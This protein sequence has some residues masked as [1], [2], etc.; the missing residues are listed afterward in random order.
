M[1]DRWGIRR[2]LSVAIVVSLALVLGLIGVGTVAYMNRMLKERVYGEAQAAVG[3]GA[4]QI[5]GFFTERGRVVTT[6]LE[7]PELRSW[8]ESYRDFRRPLAGDRGYRHVT[9]LFRRIVEDDPTVLSAFFAVAS[10]GEYFKHDG[11]VER[12]GYD[13]RK[14]WW[15][16]EALDAGG[17]Y[18]SRP[19]MDAET[20]DIAV[21]VQTTVRD[22]T[23]RLVGVSGIDV[24]LTTVGEL[25]ERIRY[26]GVGTAFLTDGEGRVVYFP[27]VEVVHDPDSGLPELTRAV[28]G[29]G[30]DELERR[31]VSAPAGVARVTWKGEPQLAFWTPVR[32]ER[33][34]LEWRLGLL[35]PEEVVLRPLRR[36]RWLSA[37]AVLFTIA[38]A[39]GV[40]LLATSAIVTRPIGRLVDRFRD[41]ASGEGDLT[42]SVVVESSD[43]LGELAE[44]FNRFVAGIRSDVAAIAGLSGRLSEASGELE[45]LAHRIAS[46]TEETSSQAGSVSAAAEQVNVSVQSVAAAAEQ[47]GSSIAE[48]AKSAGEAA[49]V[50]GEA[51][52]IARETVS[53]FGELTA[54]GEQIVRVVEVIRGIAEQT[55]L[56]ALNATIEAARAGEAGRGFAVVAGEVKALARQTA[57]ATEEIE[58]SLASIRE[59]TGAAGEAIDRVVG[60]IDRIHEIQTVIASAV[61]EQSATTAEI[62]QNVAEAA[63]GVDEIARSVAGFAAVAKETAEGAGAIQRAADELS[64]SAA[65]LKRIVGRFRY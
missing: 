17:L 54:S 18:V 14:R 6:M 65:E 7:D 38:V 43:E 4:R 52:E 63:R 47:M 39:A 40:L 21:T 56:L 19:G 20:G 45:G 46:A 49:G 28:E 3:S 5:A 64:R 2:K 22:D 44:Q 23:G 50:A 25:V 59:L 24:L 11:R 42:R 29:G 10:T 60:I 62:G 41:I 53:R 51:V 1:L 16:Q 48:I 15:W 9:E 31:M 26:R 55:N 32:A 61:E 8:F 36:H 33:P 35:V 30:F 27:G 13:A 58:A 37:I 57:E 12:E 34:G